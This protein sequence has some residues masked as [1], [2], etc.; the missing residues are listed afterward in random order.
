ME[1]YLKIKIRRMDNYQSK[2]SVLNKGAI[3]VNKIMSKFSGNGEYI[4]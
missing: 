2:P 4:I 3:K 1:F